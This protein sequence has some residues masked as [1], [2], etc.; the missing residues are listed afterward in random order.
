MVGRVPAAGT[1]LGWVLDAGS[2]PNAED[3]GALTA[4][5]L[6]ADPRQAN[7]AYVGVNARKSVWQVQSGVTAERPLGSR[8]QLEA[9]AFAVRRDLDNQLPFAQIVLGRWAWGGRV[10]ATVVSNPEGTLALTAG[11]DLQWQRDDRLNRSPDGS[12]VTRDQLE[13]VHE[14]GPFAQLRVMPVRRLTLVAGARYDIVGF[15]VDDRLTADGDG[16]GDRTMNAPSGTLGASV[17]IAQPLVVWG[18]VGTAFETPTTTELGNTPDGS[19]GFNPDLEPQ[20]ATEL[21]VGARLTTPGFQAGGALFHAA[22]R[23]E[24]ISYE[25]PADPGRRY[26]RNAGRAR[27]RGIELDAAGVLSSAVSLAW[28]YTLSDLRFTDF[29]TDAATYDGNR[30]PGVPLHLARVAV[31]GTVGPLRMEGELRA[32]SKTFADDANTARADA[33]WVADARLEVHLSRGEW[34]ARPVVGVENLFD[35]AYVAAVTVNGAN[36]RYYEPAAGRT[37]YVGLSLRAGERRERR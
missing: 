31:I 23:D 35:R 17:E 2:Y 5:E 24:L 27:H 6:A 33:W 36:G 26:F 16:S 10:V 1:T 32:A 3:P 14:I 9:A 13:M 21:E 11:G 20:K 30:I 18:R 37:V 15:A 28:T 34:V 7:P 8:G 22:V 12:G 19:G 4:E 29:A 25:V